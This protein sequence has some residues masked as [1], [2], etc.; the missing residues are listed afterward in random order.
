MS[1][2]D[3]VG[4]VAAALVLA[5]FCMREMVPLRIAALC[6]N[7]AFI[8][9]G[10]A[11][12]LAP[13]W[14]LHALLLAMNGYRLLEAFAMK[15]YLRGNRLPAPVGQPQSSGSRRCCALATTGAPSSLGAGNSRRSGKISA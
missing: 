1:L 9:Y 3:L 14:L 12:G 8:A 7:L 13:V 6:S 15:S 2:W 10:L 11:L 4:Y 5:A